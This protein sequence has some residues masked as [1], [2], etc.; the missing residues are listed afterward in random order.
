MSR[1]DNLTPIYQGPNDP[2]PLRIDVCF[3]FTS[4]AF[5]IVALGGVIFP[6]WSAFASELATATVNKWNHWWNIDR[7]DGMKHDDV[8]RWPV[9]GPHTCRVSNDMFITDSFPVQDFHGQEMDNSGYCQA[10]SQLWMC[11]EDMN[12]CPAVP[13]TRHDEL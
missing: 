7:M 4:V 11:D 6:I 12:V 1:Y 9:P 5:T 2:E 13:S 3:F 8:E 10:Y